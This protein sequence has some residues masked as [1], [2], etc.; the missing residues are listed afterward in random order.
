MRTIEIPGGTTPLDEKMW[1]G[2]LTPLMAEDDLMVPTFPISDVDVLLARG[3]PR[4]AALLIEH[5]LVSDN[6]SVDE[7]GTF[8]FL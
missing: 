1:A 4:L 8:S 6:P 2:S 3:R 7:P 5:G